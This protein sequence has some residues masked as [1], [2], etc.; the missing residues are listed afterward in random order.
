VLVKTIK[1]ERERHLRA[2]GRHLDE[3]AELRRDGRRESMSVES[4]QHACTPNTTA[5][6]LRMM[7]MDGG[8]G[9]LGY[10]VCS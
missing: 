10:T 4:P 8:G 7:L 9:L 3:A 2:H 6:A 1:V 5:M